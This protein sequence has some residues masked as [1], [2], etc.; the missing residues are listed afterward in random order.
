MPTSWNQED[1]GVWQLTDDAPS[2]KRALMY[3]KTRNTGGNIQL[4]ASSEDSI[5]Q[6]RYVIENSG[7]NDKGGNGCY[8]LAQQDLDAAVDLV[9]IKVW[10]TGSGKVEVHTCPS[11]GSYRKQFAHVVT[12]FDP[13][14]DGIWTMSESYGS[15]VY[16]KTRNTKSGRVE[17]KVASRDSDYKKQTRDIVTPFS[18]AEANDGTFCIAPGGFQDARPG[19]TA[20]YTDAGIYFIKHKN[21]RKVQVSRFFNDTGQHETYESSLDADD[22]GQWSIGPGNNLWYI[23]NRNTSSGMIEFYAVEAKWQSSFYDWARNIKIEGTK[24]TAESETRES[25]RWS[26]WKTATIDL[27]KAFGNDNGWFKLGSGGFTTS[28]Q[29]IRIERTMLKADLKNNNGNWQPAQI[30]LADHLANNDGD[31]NLNALLKFNDSIL[32]GFL[33]GVQV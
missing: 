13:E 27:D 28:A 22:N 8:V 31:W 24:I 17:V 33:G 5:Y 6:N 26:H 25:I 20:T 19:T 16:I 12:C 1:N 15:L 10:N 3:I 4:F 29:N 9:Y 14:W 18:V 23:E 2:G 30:D 11:S 32:R 21:V 7:F